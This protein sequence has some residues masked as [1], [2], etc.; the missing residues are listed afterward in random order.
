MCPRSSLLFEWYH[1]PGVSAS[2]L[3]CYTE[4]AC[5]ALLIT[6]P[7][8]NTSI[9]NAT[10]D[11]ST[12][13]ST[14]LT[15]LTSSW[16]AEAPAASECGW[17]RA[18]GYPCID[19]IFLSWVGVAGKLS[20]SL[21]VWAYVSF[22]QSWTFRRVIAFAQAL[23]CIFSFADV[24]W[25]MRVNQ[26]IGISDELW[27]FFGDEVVY[28]FAYKFNQLPFLIYAAKLCP[29][30]VE[31]SMF[32]LFMGLS[33]F[34]SDASEYVG[35]SILEL[36]GGVRAPEFRNLV[37]YVLMQSVAKA[38]PILLIPL[39]VPRGTPGGTAKEM[40]AGPAVTGETG[41]STLDDTGTRRHCRVVDVAT[42]SMLDG[43]QAG[44]ELHSVRTSNDEDRRK[45]AFKV[46]ETVSWKAEAER[47]PEIASMGT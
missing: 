36:F 7:A 15:N 34:G 18:R 14:T 46:R 2:D 26:H 12:L 10:L 17:A 43:T 47:S 37:P 9:A 40:G 19:P 31:A 30:G 13:A 27:L 4:D 44:S 42:T 22:L 16:E 45:H 24:M 5:Q 41:E 35:A 32:S 8:A 23:M 33:N 3:R 20:L 28:D 39:L 21:A 6:A 25:V 1:D 11:G 29:T 38:L